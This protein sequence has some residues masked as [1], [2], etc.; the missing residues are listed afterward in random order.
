MATKRKA[1]KNPEIATPSVWFEK[2]E[3]DEPGEPPQGF[4]RLRNGRASFRVFSVRAGIKLLELVK[5]ARDIS[6]TEAECQTVI[7][8]M[9][10]DGLPEE[11]TSHDLAELDTFWW[12]A[13]R[14]FHAAEIRRAAEE[15]RE[16]APVFWFERGQ[17]EPPHGYI[18]S[19]EGG[20]T[21]PIFSQERGLLWLEELANGFGW[22]EKDKGPVAEALRN[23]GLPLSATTADHKVGAILALSQK[24]EE[25]EAA[26]KE[27]PVRLV[28][29]LPPAL[30]ALRRA[31]AEAVTGLNEDSGPSPQEFRN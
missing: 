26:K 17:G 19:R 14:K 16:S 30:L 15:I 24:L 18:C 2:I 22:T 20:R 11:V 12:E 27:K 7:D 6:V 21:P 4:I 28:L 1:R 23:S 13:C 3:A 9:R 31:S 10:R 8:R 29:V 25:E 5:R